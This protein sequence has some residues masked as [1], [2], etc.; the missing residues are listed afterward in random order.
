M[1]KLN[2]NDL[3][4]SDAPSAQIED[5]ASKFQETF[6]NLL[7]L[8]KKGTQLPKEN[9][10]TTN[11]SQDVAGKHLDNSL[12][13]S[14]SSVK[15][16]PQPTTPDSQ[17]V[18][19]PSPYDMPS[20]WPEDDT[21]IINNKVSTTTSDSG[22]NTAS[23]RDNASTLFQLSLAESSS[24]RTD[25]GKTTSDVSEGSSIEQNEGISDFLLKS[26]INEGRK[27]LKLVDRNFAWEGSSPNGRIE[28]GY[29]FHNSILLMK[30]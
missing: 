25:D 28:F 10:I 14:S 26:F 24:P 21:S 8:R 27:C 23:Q 30:L 9:P 18:P 7:R 4:K 11:D 20:P 22:Y 16:Q 13:S 1:G 6:A 5:A 3:V 15:R 12:S 17:S 2:V 19:T 29:F